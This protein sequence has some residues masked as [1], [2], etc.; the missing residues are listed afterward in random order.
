MSGVYHTQQELAAALGLSQSVISRWLK[1]G[2]CPI[3]TKG[4]WTD[5]HVALLGPWRQLLQEDRATGLHPKAA[6]AP[7]GRPAGIAMNMPSSDSMP[8]N[9]RQVVDVKLKMERMTKIRLERQILEGSYIDKAEVERRSLAKVLAVKS[10]LMSL[11]ARVAARCI[12]L[13]AHQIQELL[14]EEARLIC[15][16]FARP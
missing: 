11:G 4:P 12:G 3:P 13:Q 2:D 9:A 14:E 5:Q 7:V 16:Q 8:A 1:R 15:G 10:S 6:E